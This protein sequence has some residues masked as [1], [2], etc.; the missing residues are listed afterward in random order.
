MQLSSRCFSL[1]LKVK[2]NVSMAISISS[3]RDIRIVAYHI[4][5]YATEVKM[6]ET[7]EANIDILWL[8]LDFVQQVKLC[9]L[10]E[11]CN[12]MQR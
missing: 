8:Y 11:N 2:Q 9:M 7:D 12:Y 6:S 3:S 5:K 10:F 4:V 1:P